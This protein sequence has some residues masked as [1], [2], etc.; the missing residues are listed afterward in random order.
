MGVS[1]ENIDLTVILVNKQLK[2][3]FL[4]NRMEEKFRKIREE[5]EKS[6][7]VFVN[8]TVYREFLLWKGATLDDLNSVE[9]GKIHEDLNKDFEPN[10]DFRQVAFHRVLLN[11]TNREQQPILANYA[12]VTQIP[13][14]YISSKRGAK[15]YFDRSRPLL[16]FK[17][18]IFELSFG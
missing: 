5:L 14:S 7:F 12:G 10:M 6:G 2:F 16:C 18:L 9:T 1:I 4:E 17:Y 15:V 13:S 11:D 3:Y 8:G